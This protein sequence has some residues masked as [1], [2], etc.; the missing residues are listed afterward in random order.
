MLAKGAPGI[1]SFI[2]KQMTLVDRLDIRQ[3]V[4]S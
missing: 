3:D 2:L 4:L 1:P